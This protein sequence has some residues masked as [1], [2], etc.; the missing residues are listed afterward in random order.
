MQPQMVEGIQIFNWEETGHETS[1][2]HY[3]P[4]IKGMGVYSFIIE[5]S[6]NRSEYDVYTYRQVHK[7]ISS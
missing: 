3:S 1:S 5:Y 4:Y 7:N 6:H 2:S